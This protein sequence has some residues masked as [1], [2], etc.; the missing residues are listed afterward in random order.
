MQSLDAAGNVEVAGAAETGS[1]LVIEAFQKRPDVVFLDLTLPGMSAAE[2]T[3]HINRAAPESAVCLV[4]TSESQPG[5]AEAMDAGASEFLKKTASGEQIAVV[6][7]R[8]KKR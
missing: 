2:A 3:R 6:L 8:I 4:G 1:D 5:I 7:S